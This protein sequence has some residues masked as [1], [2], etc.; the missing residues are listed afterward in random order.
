MRVGL[1]I[2]WYFQ[3][4]PRDWWEEYNCW[5]IISPAHFLGMNV[6]LSFFAITSH[7]VHCS[8]YP[9]LLLTLGGTHNCQCQRAHDYIS[10][11]RGVP[12]V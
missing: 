6:S 12:K 11:L 3:S 8:I 10:V 1:L 2:F 7:S 9:H 5:S 4:L